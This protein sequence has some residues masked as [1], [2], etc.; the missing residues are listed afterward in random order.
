MERTTLQLANLAM[1]AVKSIYNVNSFR[2][3]VDVNYFPVEAA[4][5]AKMGIY[6]SRGLQKAYCKLFAGS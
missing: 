5:S 4:H 2:G 6:L 1:S 3:R